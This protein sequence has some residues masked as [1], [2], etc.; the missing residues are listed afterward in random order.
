M[1]T[2]NIKRAKRVKGGKQKRDSFK[3]CPF[4]FD[5]NNL[6]PMLRIGD[7]C[8]D[9]RREYAGIIPFTRSMWLD[10]VGAGHIPP[11]VQMGKI[12]AWPREVVL[13]VMKNGIP[14]GRRGPRAEAR[15]KAHAERRA[16]EAATTRKKGSHRKSTAAATSTKTTTAEADTS[17]A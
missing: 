8:R 3:P 5:P 17:P 6:P 10:A 7:I 16:A 13:D 9:A 15:A 14:R 11:P 4:N 2:R 1:R 12:I